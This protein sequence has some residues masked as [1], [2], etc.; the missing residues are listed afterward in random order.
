MHSYTISK[1]ELLTPRFKGLNSSAA[2]VPGRYT[3]F[4]WRPWQASVLGC[5]SQNALYLLLFPFIYTSRLSLLA[6]PVLQLVDWLMG[7]ALVILSY[8]IEHNTRHNTSRHDTMQVYM[9][10]CK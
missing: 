4:R 6:L 9:T 8:N 1:I 5:L 2:E 10:Q 7:I 3:A